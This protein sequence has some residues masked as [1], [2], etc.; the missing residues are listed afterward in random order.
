MSHTWF[1]LTSS[2]STPWQSL[3]LAQGLVYLMV[4]PGTSWHRSQASCWSPRLLKMVVLAPG[5]DSTWD[6]LGPGQPPL[7]PSRPL[8]SP[9]RQ[10]TP[11]WCCW[12]RKERLAGGDE[13][14]WLMVCLA[15]LLE[16]GVVRLSYEL[17]LNELSRLQVNLAAA[18][19]SE[20]ETHVPVRVKVT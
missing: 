19:C 3:M 7:L 16:D 4:V 2:L 14:F 18:C 9:G 5:T 17:T 11:G 13:D 6:T 20:L 15:Q 8:A 10:W 1:P 12:V